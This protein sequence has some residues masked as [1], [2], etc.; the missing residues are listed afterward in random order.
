MEALSKTAMASMPVCRRGARA[1][2]LVLGHQPH[3]RRRSLWASPSIS[4][5]AST[6]SVMKS[7]SA[8]CRNKQ[9]MTATGKEN[10]TT[11]VELEDQ[12][13]V[14][15]QQRLRERATYQFAAVAASTLVIFLAI[16]ATYYR[17]SWHLDH[18][19]DFP[20]EELCGTLLLCLGGM[21]GMEMYARWVHRYMWHENDLGWAIHKS[22]HEPRLGP[23]EAN[24]I[25]A[26]MNAAPAIGLC[27]YGF[28][29]PDVIG[30]LFF[31]TGLGI[32]LFGISY[33]FIH[34]GLVHR[35][36]PVGPIAKV[37]MLRKV[38]VAHQMHHSDKYGGVPFGMFLGPLELKDAGFEEDLEKL[39]AATTSS[40]NE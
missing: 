34:D 1:P 30:G 36:F 5:W 14:R 4:R 21:V 29:R 18:G 37:P 15:R 12:R 13:R 33:M 10:S 28:M 31:G 3:P 32:T 24:D 8:H 11:S 35:R 16:C 26:L 22:H 39:V 2:L 20:Y 19:E 40:E 38:V 25:Y 17:I 6:T 7:T 23:F 27:W 9:K